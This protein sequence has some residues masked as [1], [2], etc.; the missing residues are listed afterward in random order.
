MKKI[1]T[2][3]FKRYGRVIGYRGKSSYG[4]KSLFRIVI[5]EPRGFGWRIAYLVVRDKAIKRLEQHLHTYESFEPVKGRSLLYLSVSKDPHKI[6]CFLLDRP[7]VLYKGIWH[8]VVTLGRESEIKIT[9]NARVKSA[10]WDIG[11]ANK[12][13]FSFANR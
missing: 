13:S 12:P 2:G 3:S 11:T 6:E 1:T 8:G 10:Y 7:V 5:R 4:K 9:E